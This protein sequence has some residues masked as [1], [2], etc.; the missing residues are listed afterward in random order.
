MN[1]ILNKVTKASTVLIAVGMATAPVMAE[2]TSYDGINGTTSNFTKVIELS[3]DANVPNVT[4]KYA[5]TAGTAKTATETTQTVYSGGDTVRTNGVMPTIADVT[6]AATD[7]KDAGST[8]VTKTATIDFTG[9]EYKEPGIYR[10]VI[11][12]SGSTQAV[13]EDADSTRAVDVYVLNENG[14]LKIGGYVFHTDEEADAEKSD[15]AIDQDDKS[16]GY[17]ATYATSDLTI[18][19]TVT[20]NQASQDEYFKVTV[21]IKNAVANTV[22]NVD[23]TGADATTKTTGANAD[24]HTNPATVTVGA[25]GTVTQDFWIQ[26]GQQ[27]KLTGIA[28]TT[29]YTVVEAN[30]DYTVT[31]STVE[32]QKDAVKGTTATVT[33]DSIEADST[34]AYTNDKHGVVPTGIAMK[35]GGASAVT[36]LAGA[37][38]A[39]YIIKSKKKEDEE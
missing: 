13:T 37:G 36:I 27:V 29:G 24:T 3:A 21:T 15:T 18:S 17:T 8:S 12:E 31:T 34:V 25:D 39:Y 10:Y 33:D 19:K 26:H 30:G 20:G 22:Y 23:L 14:T 11:T 9:V 6:F 38:V 28:N 7:A 35:V 5:A 2:G 16:T 1:K 4:Y 32:G